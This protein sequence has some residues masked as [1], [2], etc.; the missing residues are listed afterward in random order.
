MTTNLI[1]EAKR[2]ASNKLLIKKYTPLLEVTPN[3]KNL[4]YRVRLL[5]VK[6]HYKVFNILYPQRPWTSPASILFFD[7]FLNHNMIG[8]EYGSG[9]ST[10]YFSKKLKYVVSIEHH[11]GWYS[12]VKKKLE[13][14]KVENVDYYLIP[15]EQFPENEKDLDIYL[16]QHNQLSSKRNFEKYYNKVNEYADC[17]F[18]FVLI[19]GRSRVRCGLNAIP[20]LNKGGIFI[21]DNSE[22]E[23]YKPL[24]KAL[25]SWPKVNTTNGFTNTTIWIKP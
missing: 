11:E 8:L 23:R 14:N 13:E 3:R 4:L 9:R 20:K 12:S 7:R 21:L 2:I 18:D 19:D 6:G 16:N 24:H 1:K 25:D 15:E 5:F 10:F 17:Y 22:R